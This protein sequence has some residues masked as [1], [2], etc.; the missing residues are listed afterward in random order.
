MDE[1]KRHMHPVIQGPLD[2]HKDSRYKSASCDSASIDSMDRPF[3]T[4]KH[5]EGELILR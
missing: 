5:R 2:L 4:S 1:P 3:K